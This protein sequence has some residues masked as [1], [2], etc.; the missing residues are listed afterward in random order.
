MK[1]GRIEHLL[2]KD[3]FENSEMLQQLLEE[4]L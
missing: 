2:K 1:E 4:F 3:Q